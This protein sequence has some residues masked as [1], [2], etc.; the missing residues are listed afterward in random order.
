MKMNRI[1]FMSLAKAFGSLLLF[2]TAFSFASC[3]ED[4]S[5]SDY[6]V[7]TEMTVSDYIASDTENF[8]MLK[9]IFDR[10]RLGNSANASTL[11]NVLS[12]R[13]NYTVFAPNNEGI[14]KFL[15]SVQVATVD[16][17]SDEQAQ[18]VA[19]S[20]IIDNGDL[21]AYEEAEFPETGGAF[22]IANLNDRLLTSELQTS[23]TTDENGKS[24]T[25]TYYVINGVAKVV[26][27]Q[28]EVS[29]GIVHQVDHVI[30]PS[31]KN[32]YELIATADNMKVFSHL[33]EV[34]GWADYLD[35]SERDDVYE[36]EEHDLTY[37][38]SGVPGTFTVPQSRYIGFTAF[39]EPDDIYASEWGVSLATDAEGN[40]TNWEQVMQVVEQQCATIHPEATSSDMTSFDNAVNKFVAYHILQGKMAYNQFVHHFNEYNYQYGTATKPQTTNMPTN[41]WDYYMTVGENPMLVKITQ[42]GS[43]STVDPDAINYPIYINRISEYTFNSE[44]NTYNE[45]GLTDGYAGIKIHSGNGAYDT[46]ARNGFYFPIDG[47]MKYS[48][49]VRQKLGSERMRIDIT[50][51]LPEIASNDIRGNGYYHFPNGYFDNIMNESS[52]TVNMYLMCS[53]SS[54]GTNWRDYQGDEFLFCGLYDFVM[55][56]PPVPV[57]GTYELRTGTSNNS[58]RGMV[59]MYVG[60]DP[61]TLAPVGLPFDLRIQPPSISIPWVADV[62]GD[63]ETNAENDKLMRNQGYMKGPKY[64]T[65]TNGQG[66]TP[67][68]TIA[69]CLRRIITTQYFDANKTYYIRFKSALSNSTSQFFLDYFELVPSNI[70]NG[71]SPEDVW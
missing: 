65:M 24:T 57:S 31:T 62:E 37:V 1:N 69:A 47:I 66:N 2:C 56:L 41:V 45:T 67:C 59:Q 63:D 49:D 61:N 11:T 50:T 51:I 27:Y 17:L 12:A 68:R 22:A 32:L 71:T 60:S 40:V 53:Y 38:Q 5:E 34:T 13:G 3:S 64:F 52:G 20:C 43:G 4:I 23:T 21:A 55:K 35:I 54:G 6:A 15:D 25:S 28:T 14:Q 10:V 48:T 30:V 29:N 33:L 19:L 44:S 8:S 58:L 42:V 16:E 70:Y 9:A 7:K 46:D 26:G 39:V 18:L 36:N